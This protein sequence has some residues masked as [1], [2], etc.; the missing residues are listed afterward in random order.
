MIYDH[1]FP[2]Q[3][4]VT[5]A[6]KFTA[7]NPILRLG[8]IGFESDTLKF[9]AGDGATSWAFLSYSGR[10]DLAHSNTLDHAKEAEG[11]PVNAVA[12]T[13]TLTS[14]ETAPSDG[15][16]VTIGD[17][18]YTFKTALT[19]TEGEV[20]I[21]ASAAAALDNLKAAVNHTGTPD[22]DYSCA[23][24]HP[25][26]EATTNTDTTQVFAAKVKGVAGDEIA[27]AAVSDHLT[28]GAE[29]EALANGVDG[30]V[31]VAGVAH[32]DGTYLYVAVDDNTIADANWRRIALGAAY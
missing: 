12:S 27:V 20:L 6:A 31:G 9:K 32:F 23:A 22:T 28:F 2:M 17:V 21:G 7:A 26:V 4:V 13:G 16:T 15:D 18:T 3:A 25:D 5:T 29:V 8:E 1:V 30:T 24:A 10:V 19:P 11:T 14:D